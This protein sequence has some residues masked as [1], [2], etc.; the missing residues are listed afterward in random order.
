MAEYADTRYFLDTKGKL[1]KRGYGLNVSADP[2]DCT[3]D[4]ARLV[5]PVSSTRLRS[6][7][8]DDRCPEC[9]PNSVA[10]ERAAAPEPERKRWVGGR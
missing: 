1:H 7:V 10:A 6:Y 4:N 9:F 5:E 3:T 2:G 8:G